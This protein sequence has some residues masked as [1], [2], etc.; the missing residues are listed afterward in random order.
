MR[1][2]S[3]VGASSLLLFVGVAQ[4]V[5]FFSRMAGF[6]YGKIACWVMLVPALLVDGA[7]LVDPQPGQACSPMPWNHSG[8]V[9]TWH[10]CAKG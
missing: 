3:L 2:C 10:S 8:T 4:G 6:G 5:W 1:A 9:F 7:P